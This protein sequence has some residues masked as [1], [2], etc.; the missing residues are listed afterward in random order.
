MKPNSNLYRWD[1]EGS[2]DCLQHRHTVTNRILADNVMALGLGIGVP[3]NEP[4]VVG[5]RG[6]RDATSLWG[7]ALLAVGAVGWLAARRRTPPTG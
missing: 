2:V 1:E 4:T 5:V 6:A 7:A 3:A